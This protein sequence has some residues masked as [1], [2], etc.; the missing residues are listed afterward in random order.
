MQSLRNIKLPF[1]FKVFVFFLLIF[2]LPV[3]VTYIFI[4]Q[5]AV[6]EIEKSL[7]VTI[8]NIRKDILYDNGKWDVAAYN[9]DFGSKSSNPLNESPLYVITTDGFII[10]RSNLIAG[11]LDSVD[12]KHLL[13]YTSP[14]TITTPTNEVWRIIATPIRNNGK[15]IGIVTVSYYSPNIELYEEID[16]KLKESVSSIGLQIKVD[17]GKVNLKSVKIRNIPADIS[18]LVATNFN[19]VIIVNGRIP[20]YLDVSYIAPELMVRRRIVADVNTQEEFLV[21][22]KTLTDNKGLPVGIIIVGRS[23]KNLSHI[24]H[25]YVLFSLLSSLTIGL[26][27]VMLAAFLLK[28]GFLELIKNDSRPAFKIIF[29][30]RKKSV[31]QID[32]TQILV[33]YSSNQYYLCEAIFSSP[34]KLWENDELLERFGEQE[35]GG[36]T[37]KIYDAMLAINK[38]VGFRLIFHK[39]KTYRFNPEFIRYYRKYFLARES[40]VSQFKDK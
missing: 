35:M 27:L 40:Q 13:T 29:F 17:G 15:I 5:A 9:S 7:S 39:E 22:S 19:Q 30:D 23:L 32:R 24:L 31:I 10:D 26:P 38:R 37:R 20:R 8:E 18:Y 6:S 28:K 4:R 21:L 11:F 1:F 16:Q 12:F 25:N 14:Q 2:I 34:N 3:L 33:P 36:K